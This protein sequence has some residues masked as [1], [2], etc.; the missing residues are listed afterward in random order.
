[1]NFGTVKTYSKPPGV[2]PF[3]PNSFRCFGRALNAPHDL[4][5]TS[6]ARDLCPSDRYRSDMNF[7]SK[8]QEPGPLETTCCA[9][10]TTLA[11]TIRKNLGQ[12]ISWSFFCNEPLPFFGLFKH[13]VY[14]G[15]VFAMDCDI[16]QPVATFSYCSEFLRLAI[17]LIRQVRPASCDR[18]LGHEDA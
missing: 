16:L 7:H 6:G 15:L 9:R 13:L 2:R 4:L 12:E 8:D 3:C 5:M 18:W 11:Q 17:P 1:M 10:D 14:S